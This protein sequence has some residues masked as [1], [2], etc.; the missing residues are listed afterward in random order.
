MRFI[1]K[2]CFVSIIFSLIPQIAIAEFVSLEKNSSKSCPIKLSAAK[3]I[4]HQCLRISDRSNLLEVWQEQLAFKFGRLSKPEF[5]S[6]MAAYS[7]WSASKS[8]V[9]YDANK[10]YQLIDFLPPLIQALNSHRFIPEAS[11]L[12]RIPIETPPNTQKQLYMNCWGLLYEVLRA[13]RNPQAK[14]AIFMAQG[15]LML[16]QLRHSSEKLLTIDE[17]RDTITKSLTQPGDI[18]LV[19]HRSS[20]GYEYLD[21]VAIAID[22]GVYFEKA[23]TGENVP[24]RIIDE[25]TLRQ[26][27]QPGVF[28]YE[29]RRLKENA[30]LP[31]S[32]KIFSLN[33]PVVQEEFALLKKI[34]QSIRRNTSIVWEEEEKNL[35]TSSWFHILNA[36]PI[37]LN[38]SGRA[39][40]VPIDRPLLK[41]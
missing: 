27:W 39:K 26:I 30:V 19:M 23:G 40:L 13:A 24:I 6:L 11:Q 7:G 10:T 3:Q 25:A 1:F 12:D 4:E 36:I 37:S 9:T 18:I 29:V 28:Y 21:H 14:P 8:S 34:P 20:T 16:E 22:D 15:S 2:T 5:D 33:A 41:R 32:Q 31:H 38:I 35:V 17:P